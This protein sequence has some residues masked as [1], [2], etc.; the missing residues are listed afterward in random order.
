MNKK[1]LSYLLLLFITIA[2]NANAQTLSRSFTDKQF[3]AA[4]GTKRK[5]LADGAVL[6]D[7]RTIV[8]LTPSFPVS[9]GR[10]EQDNAGN[11][12]IGAQLT[13][14]ASYYLVVGKAFL[15]DNGTTQVEPYFSIG[16]HIDGGLSQNTETAGVVGN[17]NVGG[18]VGFYKYI[19]V[20]FAYDVLNKTPVFGLGGRVDLFSFTHGSGSII[21]NKKDF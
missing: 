2:F 17:L 18:S 3:T 8:L 12:R 13:L 6:A 21:L 15:N 7:P 4:D 1:H 19:N 20:L 5:F 9:F 11:W 14:G 10:L 16:A